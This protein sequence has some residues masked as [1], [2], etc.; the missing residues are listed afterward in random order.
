MSV[1]YAILGFLSVEPLT[2]YDLKKRFTAAD[3]LHWSGNNNQIYTTLVELHREGLVDVAAVESSAPVKKRY[4][5]TAPGIASLR[6]WLVTPAEAP[7]FRNTF[8][9]RLAWADM[10]ED[11]ALIRLIDAY[12]L[13]VEAQLALCRERSRRRSLH[14]AR[15]PREDFL[16]EMIWLNKQLALQGE[17]NWLTRLRSGLGNKQGQG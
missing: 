5:I 2:G 11:A 17:L 14:L 9:T 4:T 8:L 15:T 16:W 6:Q 10:L 7:P 1:R 13:E 3:F 12:Q